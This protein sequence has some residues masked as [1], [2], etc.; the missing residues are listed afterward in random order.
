M[1]KVFS[2]PYIMKNPH[3][4]ASKWNMWC[5]PKIIIA[6]MTKRLEAIYS[7]E[8]QAIGVGCYAITDF[9][10]NDPWLLLGILNSKLMTYYLINMFKDKHLQ[11]GY[12][13]INKSTIESLPLPKNLVYNSFI[14]KSAS[15]ITSLKKQNPDADVSALEAAINAEVYKLYHLTDAEIAII[16]QAVSG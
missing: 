7:E 5:R 8:P 3:I 9:N 16:E 1:G 12:L 4:A 15:E 10:G 2:R 13:A 14:V 11:G 6:G